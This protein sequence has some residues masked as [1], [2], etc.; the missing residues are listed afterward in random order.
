MFYIHGSPGVGK[1]VMSRY[2]STYL[3]QTL[4]MNNQQHQF[5]VY[6]FCDDK[7][8]KRRTA[9]NLLCSILFHILIEDEQLLRYVSEDAM[10]THNKLRDDSIE[11]E[12]LCYLWDALLSIIQRSRATQFR[13]I[14]DAVDELEPSSRKNVAHELSQILESDTV[15]QLKILFTDRQTPKYQF[16]NQATLELGASESR[17]DVRTYIR[18]SIGELSNEVLI[19]PKFKAA[20]EDEIAMMANGTFLHASL[21]FANFTRGVTDWTPRVIRTRLNDL[22]KLPASLEAYYAGLLR[23]IPPDF[24]RKARRAFI[25]VLGS[26]SRAPLT[27][28]E[29]HYAISVN[30]DQQSWSDLKEDISYNFESSFQKAC[31]YL[32]KIDRNG[33]VVFSHQTV[34]ELFDSASVSTREV[35]EEVLRSYRITPKDI[36]VEIVQTLITM[37][38][39]RDFDRYH[40]ESSLM[41]EKE[42][43]HEY[44]QDLLL[45]RAKGFPLLSYAMRYWCQF[46]NVSNESHIVKGLQSFFQSFQGNYFRL[47]AGPWTHFKREATPDGYSLLPLELPSLHHC[48]QMGDFPKTVCALMT[49][50]AN[51]NELDI[52][53]MSPL[54]WACTRGHKATIVALLSNPRL[55][56]NSGLSGKNRPI[57]VALDWLSEPLGGTA[58]IEIPLLI[59]NDRRT[60]VNAEGVSQIG[61]SFRLRLR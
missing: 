23:H 41:P 59:L 49:G 26:I 16:S 29:I 15:G 51:V 3:L 36:D 19:E 24:Q 37:L 13:F 14:I 4:K 42:L 58:A 44:A 11:P 43:H 25:W 60:D 52:N 28:K 32:L 46:D 61:Y 6:F 12:E 48:T 57:H 55:D 56:P 22:Q 7:Y 31:G 38:Q 35:D 34:K 53:G 2:I 33:F 45:E 20:I 8:L 5:V 21:A 10:K 40:V 18:R 9:L 27:L 30:H 1:T 54:H 50:G 17:D 47:A 39:F